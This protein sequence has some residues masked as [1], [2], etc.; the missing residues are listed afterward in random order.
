MS[1]TFVANMMLLTLSAFL[2]SNVLRRLLGFC[3]F[4]V[5]DLKSSSPVQPAVPQGRLRVCLTIPSNSITAAVLMNVDATRCT[6]LRKKLQ[7]SGWQSSTPSS[8]PKMTNLHPWQISHNLKYRRRLDALG[9]L[10]LTG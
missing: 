1:L 3:T 10:L 7:A 6:R 9:P 8:D 5:L 2:S 4:S